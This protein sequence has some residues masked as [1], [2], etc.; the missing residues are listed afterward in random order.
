MVSTAVVN[1]L[2]MAV[3]SIE[4]CVCLGGEKN[5]KKSWY[6]LRACLAWFVDGRA[7]EWVSGCTTHVF[8]S[9]LC[10]SRFHSD[11][12]APR[13]RRPSS[14]G[15]RGAKIRFG[16]STSPTEFRS[17]RPRTGTPHHPLRPWRA[18]AG[19]EAAD[20]AHNRNMNQTPFFC[21]V[22]GG[23]IRCCQIIFVQKAKDFF[24]P[25]LLGMDGAV[26]TSTAKVTRTRRLR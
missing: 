12:P 13:S 14:C 26:Q 5:K 18:E 9:F 11:R 3:L 7:G 22:G 25:A 8:Q 23:A 6:C 4:E 10:L 24:F 2:Y 16:C 1:T 17:W 21:V 19:A 15:P 20:Q